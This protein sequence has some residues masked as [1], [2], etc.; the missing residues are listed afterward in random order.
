MPGR[1]LITGDIAANKKRGGK[2][3]L[4]PSWE[5]D[6]KQNKGADDPVLDNDE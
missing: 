4:L 5:E 6:I 1:V 2:N 3:T